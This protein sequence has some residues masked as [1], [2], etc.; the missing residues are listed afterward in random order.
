MP[1]QYERTVMFNIEA[2]QQEQHVVAFGAAQYKLSS[3]VYR[4]P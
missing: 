2:L 3:V 4:L 1:E